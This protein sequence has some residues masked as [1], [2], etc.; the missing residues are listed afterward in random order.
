MSAGPW[1]PPGRRG[2]RRRPTRPQDGRTTDPQSGPWPRGHL[3]SS[4]GHGR[5]G[6][7][8]LQPEDRAA[9]VRGAWPLAAGAVALAWVRC[10]LRP[11]TAARSWRLCEPGRQRTRVALMFDGDGGLP[12][13]DGG[14]RGDGVDG[15]ILLIGPMETKWPRG[16]ARQYSKL[17][18]RYVEPMAFTSRTG[19]PASPDGRRTADRL[20]SLALAR[21]R[22][23]RRAGRWRRCGRPP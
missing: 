8:G 7:G 2:D 14:H 13:R 19:G 6:P 20:S 10:D 5:N 18:F 9:G 4:T 21:F 17:T 11:K 3:M 12:R 16:S 15:T 1:A 22:K 23:W